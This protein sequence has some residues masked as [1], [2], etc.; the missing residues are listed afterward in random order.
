MPV[1]L[2]AHATNARSSSAKIP[3]GFDI[4]DDWLA[5][6]RH[7]PI[8]ADDGRLSLVVDFASDST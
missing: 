5:Q 7:G 3:Y 4:P 6:G 1:A 2:T 8:R